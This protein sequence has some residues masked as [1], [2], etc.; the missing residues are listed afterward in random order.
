MPFFS[1]KPL[2]LLKLLYSLQMISSELVSTE[3]HEVIG[4]RDPSE[5][6]ADTPKHNSKP[7]NMRCFSISCSND[8]VKTK[9]IKQIH[10]LG[11]KVCENLANY[12]NSCTHFIC[13]KPSRSEKML[14][15]VA[16]GKWVLG[17]KY[18]EKS[19]DANQFLDVRTT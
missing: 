1:S 18:I 10:S 16:A 6:F 4:W 17:L 3:Q 14:S 7:K 19:Y 9:I 13:E 11:G 12:D 15:C 5:V 8:M 2:N